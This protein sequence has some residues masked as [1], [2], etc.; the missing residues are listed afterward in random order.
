MLTI[1][2]AIVAALLAWIF[3]RFIVRFWGDPA[4]IVIIPFIEET[5]KSL[6]PFLVQ[7]SIF[8]CHFIFGVIEAIWDIKVNVKGLKPGLMSI[9]THTLFGIMTVAVYRL[10][11]YLSLGIMAGITL[12]ILWNRCIIHISDRLR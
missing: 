10:A 2:S 6:I 12:H 9:L 1:I 11:G 7:A 8:Y 4:I 5:L 3:N